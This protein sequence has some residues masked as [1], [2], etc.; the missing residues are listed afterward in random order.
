V[1]AL[2]RHWGNLR[3]SFWFLPSLIVTFS[4]ALAAALIAADASDGERWLTRWPHVFGADAAG[5]RAILSTIAGSMITVVGVTFSMTL[6][7]L[8]LASSQYTSRILRTFIRDRVTQVVLGVFAGIFT[9]CLI[10]LR[11]IRGGEE[12]GFIASLAMSFGIVL[13]IGG[14]GTLIYFIHHIATSIQASSLIAVV[15][16]E[17][18]EAIDRLFPGALGKPGSDDSDHGGDHGGESAP[19]RRAGS[20]WQPVPAPG[21]GYIQSVDNAALLRLAREHE[22]VVRMEH[23][24]GN[25]VVEGTPLV[26]LALPA[27]PD[28]ALVAEVQAAFTLSRHR[29]LHQD[30]AFGVR[31][32]VDMAMRALSPSIND[33]TTAVMCVDYL[34][35]ILARLATRDIPSPYRYEDDALRVIAI[36]QTFSGLVDESFDQIRTSAAG[37]VAVMLRVLGALQTIGALTDRPGRR[38]VLSEHLDR[39]TELAERTLAAPHDRERFAHRC[40]AVL[41][42]WA[43]AAAT[44]PRG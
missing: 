37:N 13:A 43:A 1:N 15:A 8:A 9:Y 36:G 31:Q 38:L 6:V 11:S 20:A 5:A 7:T 27:A 14:I 3:T 32:I 40:A 39:M 16:E 4:V 2:R 29:T 28:D 42:S 23:G 26:S 17:T 18:L 25:F 12:T 34:T 33:T 24:I 10:V 30:C 21:N 41:E 44:R 22:M 19:A 35:A